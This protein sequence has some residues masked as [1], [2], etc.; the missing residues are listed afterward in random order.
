MKGGEKHGR[1]TPYFRSCESLGQMA[2]QGSLAASR[3]PE[4]ARHRQ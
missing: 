1:Y 2:P 3:A 4:V